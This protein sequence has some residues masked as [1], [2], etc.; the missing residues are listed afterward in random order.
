MVETVRYC[1][2]YVLAAELVSGARVAVRDIV[3]LAVE[4]SQLYLDLGAET[5]GDGTAGAVGTVCAGGVF[6]AVVSVISACIL[7]FGCFAVCLAC[8]SATV[9]PVVLAFGF[10]VIEIAF[11]VLHQIVYTVILFLVLI[12][13][14]I[15]DLILRKGVGHARKIQTS[16]CQLQYQQKAA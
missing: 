16:K 10:V 7:A 2:V 14:Q 3:T 5:F 8:C 13:I 9:T 6:Y 12:N 1:F 15:N 4:D 11:A